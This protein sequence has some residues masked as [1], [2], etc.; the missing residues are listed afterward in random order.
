MSKEQHK[1]RLDV[2]AM[3]TDRIIAQ[4]EKGEVPWRKPWVDGQAPTNLISG[5]PYR[6]IN[7]LLLGSVGYNRI[8]FLTFKQ[9]K[10]L[11]ASIRK[12]EKSLPVVFWN[13]MEKEDPKTGEQKK[14]GM[15]RYYNV[16]NIEQCDNI[17]E[18]KI[19]ALIE[20]VHDP[21]KECED[22]VAQMPNPP[23]IHHIGDQAYYHPT[24][25]SISLPNPEKFT[26]SEKYY[27]T[28][29]HE[30][31]HSTGHESRLNRKEVVS[32]IKFGSENYA[33]EELTAEIGATFLKT[34]AG[35]SIDKI[36]NNA[37]YIQHWLT[38]LRND[39]RFIIH[40]SGQAQKA[41]DYILNE[42]EVE[43]EVEPVHA[44]VEQE[45]E[46]IRAHSNKSNQIS[47]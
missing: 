27:S 34:R 33:A 11:G 26:S 47:R 10:E 28:L 38:K 23:S 1:E 30:I 41:A 5:K 32:L 7:T 35:I 40:A 24:T 20:R 22:I 36:E 8:L 16:F 18:D 17:P 3:V 42:R 25:D 15:L 46:A 31:V 29:F 43:K 45:L 2:Y 14:V 4:M 21:V 37:A 19:P 39:K 13:S 12:G 44:E 9:A 6:G